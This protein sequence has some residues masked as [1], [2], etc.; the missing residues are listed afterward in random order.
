MN[1]KPL[2]LRIFSTLLILEPV[3][4]IILLSVQTEFHP[5]HI[6][7]RGLSLDAI[8]LFNFWLLFPLAG[9]L[10]IKLNPY[11]FIAYF[12]VQIYSLI[13]H[14]SYESYTWPYLSELPHLSSVL[15]LSINIILTLYI[16]LPKTRELFFNQNLRWWERG[17]RFSVDRPCFVFADGNEL[18]GHLD[19]ISHSGAL[20]SCSEKLPMETTV[21]LEFELL[22]EPFK[23]KAKIVR[24]VYN[25]QLTTGHGVQFEFPNALSALKLKIILFKIEGLGLLPK[26]R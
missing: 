4:K 21:D 19:N 2:L 18:K 24:E 20:I 22:D 1:R 8:G 6:A 13:F 7:S 10:L 17:S 9:V 11:T 26:Y 16:L 25:T 12:V 14:L 23:L 3:I 15:L 5:M